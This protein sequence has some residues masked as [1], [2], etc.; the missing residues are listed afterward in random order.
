LSVVETAN[1]LHWPV[2]AVELLGQRVGLSVC[3]LRV[4][5]RD[6]GRLM[7]PEPYFSK[8]QVEELVLRFAALDAAFAEW[9]PLDRLI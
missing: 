2:D 6:S 5:A 4:V 7:E 1:L 8:R 3:W 9:P